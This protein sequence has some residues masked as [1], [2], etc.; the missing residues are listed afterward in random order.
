MTML[1]LDRIDLGDLVMALDDHSPDH[2][3]VLEPTTG[4]IHVYSELADESFESVMRELAIDDPDTLIRIEPWP[5]HVGYGDM[6]DFIEQV[7]DPRA[8]DLLERAIAGRGAFRRFKDALADYPE[9]REAWY[10]LSNARAERRAIEWMRDEGLIDQASAEAAI[11][12]RLD[13]DSPELGE[14]FDPWQVAR[15]VAADLREVYGGR[16]R[17]VILFGSWARGD[18]HRESD[19]DLLVVL[20]RVG[21]RWAERDRID[22]ILYRHSLDHDTLVSATVCS[23]SELRAGAQPLFVRVGAEG[24]SVG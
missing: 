21:A 15:D 17:D 23:E 22:P 10:A 1:D 16:L 6:E 24:R 5:S 14:P 12:D 2:S 18:A 3:W 20:D 8:R 4:A 19:I 13:P 9:L 7:R 11:A